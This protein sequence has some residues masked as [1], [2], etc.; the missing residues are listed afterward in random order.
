MMVPAS[1]AGIQRL[2]NIVGTRIDHS[3]AHSWL[4]DNV[5]GFGGGVAQ[6]TAQPFHH[7]P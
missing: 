7:V 5:L 4:G 6:L 3:V 1:V 2:P